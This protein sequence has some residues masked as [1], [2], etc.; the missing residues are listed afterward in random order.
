[1]DD[2]SGKIHGKTIYKWGVP[3]NHHPFERDFGINHIFEG[4]PI[5]G[6]LH[7]GDFRWIV[8]SGNPSTNGLFGGTTISGNHHITP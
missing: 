6:N 8:Y 3:P 5:C 2:L 4:L 1:M 7:Y